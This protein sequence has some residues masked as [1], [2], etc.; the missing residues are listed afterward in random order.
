MKKASTNSGNRDRI[1]IFMIQSSHSWRRTVIRP[2][3]TSTASTQSGM[4]GSRMSAPFSGW[5]TYTSLAPVWMISVMTP[6]FSPPHRT[7]SGRRSGNHNR[8]PPAVRAFQK[9]APLRSSRSGSLPCSG[10]PRPPGEGCI[11]FYAD[12][13]KGAGRASSEADMLQE[14]KRS[15]QSVSGRIRKSPRTPCGATIFPT[16]I[17]VSDALFTESNDLSVFYEISPPLTAFISSPT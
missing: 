6:T 15:G 14:R 10:H 11:Y 8:A 7:R 13:P 5:M 4:A 1:S 16:A 9:P 2:S 3:A 12:G 17:S